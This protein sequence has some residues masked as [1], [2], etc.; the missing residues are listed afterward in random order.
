VVRPAV[1]VL[2]SYP[3]PRLLLDGIIEVSNN[4]SKVKPYGVEMQK[5]CEFAKNGESS[6]HVTLSS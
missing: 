3:G 5:P 6:G 1:I 4:M 2:V